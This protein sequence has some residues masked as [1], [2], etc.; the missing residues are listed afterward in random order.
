M[1]FMLNIRTGRKQ[2]QKKFLKKCSEKRQEK[3]Y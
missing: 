3:L 2:F 1:T